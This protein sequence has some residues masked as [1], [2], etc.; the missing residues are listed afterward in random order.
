MRGYVIQT[1]DRACGIIASR[2]LNISHAA[3]VIKSVHCVVTKVESFVLVNNPRYYTFTGALVA[4]ERLFDARRR[5]ALAIII[6]PLRGEREEK[7][8]KRRETRKKTRW[9]G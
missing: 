1:T 8:G 7:E 5:V 2:R 6:A 9:K 4:L 3:D